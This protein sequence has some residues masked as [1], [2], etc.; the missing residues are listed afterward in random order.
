[1][2]FDRTALARQAL[3]AALKV[4][5]KLDI[6]PSDPV[7]IYDVA[8]KLGLKVHFAA[9]PSMEGLYCAN[10]ARILINAD[11]PAG[12]Q[13]FSCAHEVGHHIFGHGDKIDLLSVSDNGGPKD[14]AEFLADCF[15]GFLLMPKLVVSNAFHRRQWTPATATSTQL[16]T[17]AGM[18][19]VGYETLIGHMQFS[20]RMLPKASAERL[21]KLSP[22]DIR[23]EILGRAHAGGLIVADTSWAGRPIDVAVEDLIL[24]PNGLQIKGDCIRMF[25]NEGR[26]ETLLEAVSPG[27]AQI[28]QNSS[29]WA[30]FVRVSRKA[31]HGHATFRHLPESADE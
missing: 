19:G 11:R 1:M 4:R 21:R 5:L 14:P 10:L 6:E 12:R 9:I 25:N 2:S 26:G 13:A 27:T 22:K 8:A 16:F 18:L 23:K 24:A 29:G 20:L 3:E 15:A 30:T 7:C 17:I 28:E 31:F